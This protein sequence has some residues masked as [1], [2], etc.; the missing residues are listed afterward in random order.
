MRWKIPITHLIR[1]FVP[2]SPQGEGMKLDKPISIVESEI[3]VRIPASEVKQFLFP[4]FP[5]ILQISHL[6]VRVNG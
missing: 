6:K 1:H 5:A 4:K 3:K 2:P